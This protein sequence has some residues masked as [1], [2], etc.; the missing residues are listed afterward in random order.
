MQLLPIFLLEEIL[1]FV[2]RCQ[3]FR[4]SLVCRE[5]HLAAR[6]AMLRTITLSEVENIKYLKSIQ[7]RG[8]HV[9]GLQIKSFHV[10]EELL[11]SNIK[12]CDMLPCL[13]AITLEGDFFPNDFDQQ[14]WI[15]EVEGLKRLKYYASQMENSTI[16][17]KNTECIYADPFPYDILSSKEEYQHLK[18]LVIDANYLTE[19]FASW[20]LPFL[21][22]LVN[23]NFTD[24]VFSRLDHL[25]SFYYM[26]FDHLIEF[27]LL[28]GL[29]TSSLLTSQAF[30]QKFSVDIPYASYE[31]RK[32]TDKDDILSLPFEALHCLV[33]CIS[34]NHI[35]CLDDLTHFPS[36]S[37]HFKRHRK[38]LCLPKTT[39]HTTRLFL[40]V[41]EE[42]FKEFFRWILKYFPSLQHLRISNEVPEDMLP[43]PEYAFPNL[44]VIYSDST[45]KPSFWTELT[46]AA[47]GLTKIYGEVD[48]ATIV[49]LQSKKLKFHPYQKYHDNQG[50][51]M[52][53]EFNKYI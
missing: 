1:S 34:L 12:L 14:K 39:F 37:F 2:E 8:V 5:F 42:E 7:R 50:Y 47:P 9:K 43:L 28:T 49:Q 27:K 38:N 52:T 26:D 33:T 25:V 19:E 17:P 11:A 46:K 36:L 41:D 13:R 40:K 20:D 53:R 21:V 30:L 48:Q 45:Q 15:S 29:H 44:T 10:L 35:P 51:F 22:D 4:L 6:P 18:R 23:D 32:Y 16:F 31:C 3:V 24:E